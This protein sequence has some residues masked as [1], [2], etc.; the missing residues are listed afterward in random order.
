MTS[1]IIQNYV[2]DVYVDDRAH[3]ERGPTTSSARGVG[4]D[5]LQAH[6]QKT[7]VTQGNHATSA[8]VGP[9]ESSG[10]DYGAGAMSGLG[11]ALLQRGVDKPPIVRATACKSPN[12]DANDSDLTD[13]GLD[14]GLQHWP[15]PEQGHGY[16]DNR[17]HKLTGQGPAP[18]LTPGPHRHKLV[19][20][21]SQ[22]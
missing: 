15:S 14:P 1:S 18:F 20:S 16:A 11:V 2:P 21:R 8:I 6:S 9:V 5:R 10:Q 13:I 4:C 17:V 22:G 3:D 19:P 12:K 7:S